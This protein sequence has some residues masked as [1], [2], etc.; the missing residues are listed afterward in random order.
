[1][2]PWNSGV[3][4]AETDCWISCPGAEA[5]SE[6]GASIIA[7]DFSNLPIK[8]IEQLSTVGDRVPTAPGDWLTTKSRLIFALYK[9]AKIDQCQG[10]IDTGE[11]FVIHL[12]TTPSRV[13][14]AMVSAAEYLG[15]YGLNCGILPA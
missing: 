6:N 2:E 13:N 12:E 14:D 7:L 11:P 10:V 5:V 9:D 8:K 15:K 1:L 3:T 4:I